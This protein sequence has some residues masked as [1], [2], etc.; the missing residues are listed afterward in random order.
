MVVNEHK[1]IESTTKT[2]ATDR[3]IALIFVVAENPGC[4]LQ[5]VVHLTGLTKSTAHRLLTRLEFLQVIDR[6]SL[7]FRYR[8][9][10]KLVW[11]IQQNKFDTDVRAVARPIMN[12]LRDQ[13]G[14]T[15]SL[16]QL[17]ESSLTVVEFCEPEADIRRVINIGR[18]TPVSYGATAKAILA[19]M[20][21]AQCNHFLGLSLSTSE[22]AAIKRE[23]P[24]IRKVGFA[25]SA[26]EISPGLTALSTPVF[27]RP[28]EVWGGLS[29]S[30]PSFRFTKQIAKDFGKQIVDA[31]NI[32]S[33][34]LGGMRP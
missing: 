32:L 25:L 14:E 27:H 28:K 5:D 31:A 13:L 20:S 15:I 3:S 23:F 4:N 22:Q 2:P 18:Q 26:G 33:R 10:R 34:Q 24:S 30:G 16:H 7:T 8:V 17:L 21:E 29:V 11:A 12:K 19:Y 9:G 1:S 6:D